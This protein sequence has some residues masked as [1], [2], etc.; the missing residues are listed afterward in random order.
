[1]GGYE[2][3]ITEQQYNEFQE[4]LKQKQKNT[5]NDTNVYPM[6]I[7]WTKIVY[8]YNPYLSTGQRGST[9]VKAFVKKVITDKGINL[10]LQFWYGKTIYNF[11]ILD[12]TEQQ[13]KYSQEKNII[14]IRDKL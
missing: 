7:D 14:D 9:D 5:Y 1:M 3:E 8:K 13:Q 2:M 12:A 11:T 4:F 6:S 10:Q